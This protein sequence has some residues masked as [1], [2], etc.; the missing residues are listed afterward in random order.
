MLMNTKDS[1]LQG[2][3]KWALEHIEFPMAPD[4]KDGIWWKACPGCR[5][6]WERTMVHGENC[7]YVKAKAALQNP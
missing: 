4:P 3:L 7:F 2:L 1:E 6:I 5:V